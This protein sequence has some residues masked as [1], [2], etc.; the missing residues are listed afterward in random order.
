MKYRK[1]ILKKLCTSIV[2]MVL[3]FSLVLRNEVMTAFA[4]SNEEMGLYNYNTSH[5]NLLAVP[6]SEDKY[7][8]S[9]NLG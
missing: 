9:R 1:K 3:S 7:L 5:C 4:W 2:C 8:Y 6:F